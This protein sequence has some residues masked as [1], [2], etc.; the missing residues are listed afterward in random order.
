MRYPTKALLRCIQGDPHG[1]AFWL[2]DLSPWD[3]WR[4]AI[5][6]NGFLSAIWADYGKEIIDVQSGQVYSDLHAPLGSGLPRH[7]RRP[8]TEDLPF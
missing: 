7:P 1:T 4:L 2:D 3:A 5:F 8:R 6:L